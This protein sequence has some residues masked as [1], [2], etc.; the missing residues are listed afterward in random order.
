MFGSKERSLSYEK[1]VPLNKWKGFPNQESNFEPTLQF[2][3]IFQYKLLEYLSFWQTYSQYTACLLEL[4]ILKVSLFFFF[5]KELH[6]INDVLIK[7]CFSSFFN[8][9]LVSICFSVKPFSFYWTIYLNQYYVQLLVL[10][11]YRVIT[12]N[13]FAFYWK[14]NFI[15]SQWTYFL[16]I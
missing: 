7:A 14:L 9:F 12:I 8:A 6:K 5:L 3:L 1:S 13:L 16:Y 10:A 11:K 2:L 4:I 15:F